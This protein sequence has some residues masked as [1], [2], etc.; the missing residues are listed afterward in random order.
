MDIHNIC[1]I[2]NIKFIEWYNQIILSNFENIPIL[3]EKEKSNIIEKHKVIL[4][5]KLINKNSIYKMRNELINLI[6]S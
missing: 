4:A 2:C 6:N 3:K 1:N 5:Y